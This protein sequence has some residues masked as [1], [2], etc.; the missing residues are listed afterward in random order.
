MIRQFLFAFILIFIAY[1]AFAECKRPVDSKKV[2]IFVDINGNELE[3]KRMEQ[4]ACERGE[5]LK[6]LPNNYQKVVRLNK[7][8]AAESSKG[9]R[10]CTR[11]PDSAKCKQMMKKVEDLS[12]RFKILSESSTMPNKDNLRKLV[13]ETDASGSSITNL[14]FSG[15][16][17]GGNFGGSFGSLSKEE[18]GVIFRDF[19]NQRD[20]VQSLLLLGCYTGVVSEIKDWRGKFPQAKLIAGYDGQAPLGDKLAGHSYIS[21]ILNKE[22]VIVRETEKKKLFDLLQNGIRNI[23]ELSAAIYVDPYC[24]DEGNTNSYY[25]RPQKRGDQRFRMFDDEGCLKVIHQSGEIRDRLSL[26]LTGDVAISNNTHGTELR[27]IY[28]FARENSHCFKNENE[29]VMGDLQS[30]MNS[31]QTDPLTDPDALMMLLFY[32]NMVVNFARYYKDDLKSLE[33]LIENLNVDDIVKSLDAKLADAKNTHAINLAL[34][35]MDHSLR[36]KYIEEEGQKIREQL[37]LLAGDNKD[38]LEYFNLSLFHEGPLT[39]EENQRLLHLQAPPDYYDK[40]GNLFNQYMSNRYFLNFVKGASPLEVKQSLEGTL[41]YSKMLIESLEKN[42]DSL[43]HLREDLKTKFWVPTE[44]N[45]KGKGRKEI[46]ANLTVLNEIVSQNWSYDVED[47]I[48]KLAK[49]KNSMEMIL[50]FRE[51]VP[52]S[53]H[54]VSDKPEA[55]AMLQS[56]FSDQMIYNSN[57]YAAPVDQEQDPQAYEDEP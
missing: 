10:T 11:S 1:S 37:L 47:S 25:Y 22:Q 57:P 34:A 40:Y 8:L 53:W 55:P 5:T 15:H 7:E 23:R 43:S 56:L 52:F 39:E 51:G 30:L 21:D 36:A 50:N 38:V 49:A 9:N 14:S 33:D 2:M 46:L 35:N 26:Y 18:V 31:N 27:N 41:S 24:S 20:S 28:N 29:N 19:P 12:T 44:D 48:Q 54:E 4:A 17:G 3:Y 13:Q 42:K 45:L 16:D 32:N 6:V